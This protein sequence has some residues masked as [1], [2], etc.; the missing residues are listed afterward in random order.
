L[1]VDNCD[2]WKEVVVNVSV[3]VQQLLTNAAG[4][5]ADEIEFANSVSGSFSYFNFRP[6]APSFHNRRSVGGK[7]LAASGGSVTSAS[8]A[9]LLRSQ[10]TMRMIV[11]EWKARSKFRLSFTK[12][13]WTIK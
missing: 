12:V 7:H 1:G 6:S 2:G 10:Q 13:D 4:S 9:T 3:E 11:S 8:T 5:E